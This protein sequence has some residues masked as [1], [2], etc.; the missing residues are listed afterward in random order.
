MRRIIDVLIYTPLYHSQFSGIM[1]SHVGRWSSHVW[2]MFGSARVSATGSRVYYGI[3]V[4]VG[5]HGPSGIHCGAARNVPWFTV[6]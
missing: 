1:R 5:R 6:Q 4:A 3:M 2:L